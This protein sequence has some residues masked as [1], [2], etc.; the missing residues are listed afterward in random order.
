MP[1][2]SFKSDIHFV[3]SSNG[4]I[5]QVY[6]LTKP[7][8]H[9]S[10]VHK[11]NWKKIAT[12]DT[13]YDSDDDEDATYERSY[14]GLMF[15]DGHGR[16][17]GQ[18]ALTTLAKHLKDLHFLVNPEGY[19]FQQAFDFGMYYDFG[20][21]YL[22]LNDLFSWP[23][24]GVQLVKNNPWS[25]LELKLNLKHKNPSKPISL[26]GGMI[27]KDK[28]EELERLLKKKDE[29]L[30]KL[31]G[32]MEATYDHQ[33]LEKEK[34]E[35][36]KVVRMKDNELKMLRRNKEDMEEASRAKDDELQKSKS[37]EEELRKIIK[38]NEEGKTLRIEELEKEIEGKKEELR[39]VK[40]EKDGNDEKCRGRIEELEKVNE[41]K[42]QELGKLRKEKKTKD[43][44]LE[45]CAKEVDKLKGEV[46]KK[47]EAGNELQMLRE[48]VRHLSK[49]RGFP[50][51]SI[52]CLPQHYS[53]AFNLLVAPKFLDKL[54]ASD[55]VRV[56]FVDD[57]SYKRPAVDSLVMY[58]G[59]EVFDVEEWW[60]VRVS[61]PSGQIVVLAYYDGNRSQISL[62]GSN[63]GEVISVPFS[64]DTSVYPFNRSFIL[65]RF[66]PFGL[67]LGFIC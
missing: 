54:L 28:Y 49:R 38:R 66:D 61:L 6:E 52:T 67:K 21:H 34:E 1:P 62:Q 37:K 4:T 50:A 7:T 60:T 31:K 36:R 65:V 29:E 55:V 25:R 33:E 24:Y 10:S 5:L 23:R 15:F 35:L 18:Q 64:R 20:I 3:G 42:E 48:K 19:C 27:S 41:A 8:I 2:F 12:I 26:S 9:L 17:E 45:M 13:D 51:Q 22:R 11:A 44:E 46:A 57:N 59:G 56:W 39:K 47:A 63:H 43:E 58:T 40:R 14:H 53:N 16:I 30:E 32:E